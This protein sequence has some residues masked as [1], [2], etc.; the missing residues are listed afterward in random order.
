MRVEA[1]VAGLMALQA[2]AVGVPWWGVLLAALGVGLAWRWAPLRHGLGSVVLGGLGMVAGAALDRAL[3]AV[4]ACHG[5]PVLGFATGGMV[6]GCTLACVL[7][8]ALA[9]RPRADLLFH[10]IV[11]ATMWTG[12]EAAVALVT[13][14]GHTAGHWTMVIG[15]GVGTA[16]GALAAAL[17]RPGDSSALGT[18]G[19]ALDA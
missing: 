12:E 19:G 15:M 1:A 9:G 2:A 7:V 11:L 3:G 14:S 18:F 8:C 10:A 4:P 5:G 6:L 17:L 16:I 13:L